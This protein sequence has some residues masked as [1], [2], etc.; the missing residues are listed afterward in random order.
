LDDDDDEEEEEDDDDDNNNN[1]DVNLRG[2]LLD[3][4]SARRA[5]FVERSGFIIL[6]LTVVFRTSC[7]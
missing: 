7:T 4:L 2:Y 1:N 3:V 5:K 6:C